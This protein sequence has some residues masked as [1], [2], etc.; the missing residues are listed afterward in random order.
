[1]KQDFTEKETDVTIIIFVML[2]S[3]KFSVRVEYFNIWC[4]DLFSKVIQ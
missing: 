2:D 1:M 4:P 3:V